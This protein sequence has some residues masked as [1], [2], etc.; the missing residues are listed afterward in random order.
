MIRCK[1]N[2]VSCHISDNCTV[3]SVVTIALHCSMIGVYCYVSCHFTIGHLTFALE[4]DSSRQQTMSEPYPVI[5]S[6]FYGDSLRSY[7]Q[8]TDIYL[9]AQAWHVFDELDCFWT[10]SSVQ[11]WEIQLGTAQTFVTIFL[12]PGLGFLWKFLDTQNLKS[13]S[14]DL[15]MTTGEAFCE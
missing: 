15:E 12:R 10:I 6:L 2:R 3:A 8:P 11:L 5:E 4:A 7:G 13:A 1:R 14:G 9:I